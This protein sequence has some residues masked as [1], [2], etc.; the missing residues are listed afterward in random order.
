MYTFDTP[1]PVLVSV[2]CPVG[3]VVVATHAL[4]TTT[5]EVVALR[6][7]EATRRAVEETV[8]EQRP[9]ASGTEVLVEVPKRG[10]WVFGR[11]PRLRVS[12]VAP[13][14]AALSFVT[15]SADVACTGRLGE[16][17]GKTASGDVDVPLAATVR[18]ETASG[19]LRVGDVDGVA[20]LRSASGDVRVGTVGGT[21]DASVVSGNLRVG[22]APLGGSAAAVSG[23]IE[24]ASVREGS[25]SVR[26]VSGDVTV[27]VVP[28]SRVH[29]DVT[30]V[31]GDLK[32]EIDL[33]EAGAGGEDAG[34]LLDVRGKTVSGDLRLRR[35]SV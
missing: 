5:V 6:D 22:A 18:V 32:S 20:E 8:V 10:G 13:E 25:L 21:L 4:P 15:A 17:R 1:G 31:S 24:L 27:G 34:P 2:E 35:A 16:V 26:S 29:V 9:A 19:D 7:D 28:G 11:E 3:D 30:T 23:D 14:G 12:V 33:S